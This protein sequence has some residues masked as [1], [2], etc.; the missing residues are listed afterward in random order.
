MSPIFSNDTYIYDM[1]NRINPW[2][3]REIAASQQYKNLGTG[4]A[5][6]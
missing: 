4:F 1:I 6:L 2:Q 3:L 5:F